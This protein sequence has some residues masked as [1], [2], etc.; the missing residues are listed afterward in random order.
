MTIS[1]SE[2]IDAS[3]ATVWRVMRDVEH[4]PEWTPSVTS[5]SLLD[6][7]PLAIGSRVRMKQ[8]RLPASELTV[9]ELEENRGFTWVS[10]TPGLLAIGRHHIEPEGTGSRIS[11]S[12]SFEGTLGSLVELLVR[13]LTQR[14]VRMEADGLKA[15]SESLERQAA[16]A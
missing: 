13:D 11:L 2:H 8:P 10:Q 14:Y 15:R 4:W 3:P 5:A 16:S 7:A 12:M 1:V 9:T 6:D